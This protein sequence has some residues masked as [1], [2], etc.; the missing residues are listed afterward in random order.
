MSLSETKNLYSSELGLDALAGYLHADSQK[1]P[2]GSTP[3]W[4][5]VVYLWGLDANGAIAQQDVPDTVRDLYVQ[6]LQLTQAIIQSGT[7][8]RLWLI[9][10]GA[11]ADGPHTLQ[12]AQ[13]PLWGL[14]RTIA[15]EHPELQC[16]CV[17]LDESRARRASL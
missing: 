13:A 11:V 2:E 3:N 1:L 4:R 9:T 10:Q 8:P 7:N 14:G 12:L 16:T 17:D 15:W 6:V 5:G